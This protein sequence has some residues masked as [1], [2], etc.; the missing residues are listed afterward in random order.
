[1]YAGANMGHPSRD[2]GF[3]IWPNVCATEVMYPVAF[4]N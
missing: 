3:V 4:T 2:E 1:M